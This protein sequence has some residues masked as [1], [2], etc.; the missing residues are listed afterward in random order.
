MT[1]VWQ[2]R[3]QDLFSSR[4]RENNL[5]W[6]L[7]TITKVHA[8]WSI[9][10]RGEGRGKEEGTATF[11]VKLISKWKKK[12]YFRISTFFNF[13]ITRKEKTVATQGRCSGIIV[14]G[15]PLFG[16]WNLRSEDYFLVGNFLVAC[17]EWKMLVRILFEGWQKSVT[18]GS[19]FYAKQLYQFHLQM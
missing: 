3:S 16:F 19:Y 4:E 18:Q 6:L 17:F 5:A 8:P 2:P 1:N 7:V 11:C 15:S 12:G 9:A 14:K 13:K 10:V